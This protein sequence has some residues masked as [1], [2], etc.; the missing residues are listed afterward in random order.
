MLRFFMHSAALLTNLECDPE[1]SAFP[2]G[3]GP[4]ESQI[5]Q[6]AALDGVRQRLEPSIVEPDS[7]VA[8]WK[9]MPIFAAI[10]CDPACQCLFHFR[11][12]AAGIAFEAINGGHR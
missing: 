6:H 4:C 5:L 3:F 12:F 8:I 7:K 11:R 1:Q 10:S 2:F 9:N